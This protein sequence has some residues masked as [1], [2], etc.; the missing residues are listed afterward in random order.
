MFIFRLININVQELKKG[1]TFLVL[2]VCTNVFQGKE[3]VK[4][5]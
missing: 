2:E 3:G 4:I 1:L 5:F